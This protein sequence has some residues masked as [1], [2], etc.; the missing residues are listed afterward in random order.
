MQSALAGDLPKLSRFF[1]K[2][3]D[4]FYQEGFCGRNI[5]KLLV[6]A[7]KA[8]IDTSGA[9][10]LQFISDG[11]I[12]VSGFYTR[13]KKHQWKALGY[14]H[15]TVLEMDGHIFDFDLAEP[16]VLKSNDYIRLQFTPPT[17]PFKIFGLDYSAKGNPSDWRVRGID[18]EK[19]KTQG[20]VVLWEKKVKE[21]FDMTSIMKIPR[22]KISEGRA[23]N[24]CQ[25]KLSSLF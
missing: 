17:E 14:F 6:E 25:K 13:G 1:K 12:K 20:D 18:A 5:I 7:E 2:N 24:I 10:V 3:Y 8:G 9:E 11:F 4:N 19:I 23:A 21:Y 15:H 22:G 16:R